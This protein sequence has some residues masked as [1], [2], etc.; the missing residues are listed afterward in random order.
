MR[1]AMIGAKGIPVE[2]GMGG[3]VERV[4]ER[5]STRLVEHGHRVTVYVRPYA[6]LHKRKVWEGVH[7]VTLPCIRV[8]HL[9]TI[10]HVFLS[11]LHALVKNYDIIHYHGVGPSTLAWIPRL[12]APRS[13]I[14]VTF[15]ARDRFH[16][17]RPWFAKAYLAFAEWTAVK[18]PHETIAVSN[19][20]WQFIRY[21]FRK[22]VAYVPNGVDL[23]SDKS[24]P[25]DRL[26][27]MGVEPNHYFLAFGRLI[28]LKAFD[29]AIAAYRG[30]DT[31]MPF[32]I[33]GAPGY[34]TRY[35]AKLLKLASADPRI[36]LLGFRQS[37]DLQQLI[38][39]AYAV[40]HPSRTEGM[41][42]AVLEAMS[43]GKLVIMSGIPENKEI[44]DH[45]AI[46]IP[47][48]NT[49]A[50]HDAFEWAVQDPA[51]VAA[52]G[53]RAREYVRDHHAWPAIVRETE[54]LYKR[55]IPA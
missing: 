18:F 29:V 16:E 32:A 25:T 36:H 1:I 47:V 28:Q 19:A 37:D 27:A 55:L 40:V 50:F 15:H 31:P 9:E 51:M 46:V 30:V 3:G 52:R 8:N 12:L 4:V 48:D 38:A 7:L 5:L 42:L 53:T 24:V 14:V 54:Q 11:T 43:Y 41:S 22:E 34:D 13:R 33:A 20:I 39:H 45:S 2:T 26:A 35:A 6:N 23:P 10:T 44:A 49:L 17:H 21:R